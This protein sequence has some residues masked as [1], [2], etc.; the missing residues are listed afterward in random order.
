MLAEKLKGLSLAEANNLVAKDMHELLGVS[1][2][3]RRMKCA[4]LGLHAL[5]N[6]LHTY[7]KESLQ[8]WNET[9]E[10]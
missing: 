10:D 5:K 4:L 3:I 1:I 9:M 8:S 6:T 2:G 7:R